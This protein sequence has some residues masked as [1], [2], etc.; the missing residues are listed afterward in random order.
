MKNQLNDGGC[1]SAW[2]KL[3]ME[4]GNTNSGWLKIL[5]ISFSIILLIGMGFRYTLTTDFA[6][7]YIENNIEKN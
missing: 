7:E 2:G 4:N 3:L 6:L 1:I 5:A